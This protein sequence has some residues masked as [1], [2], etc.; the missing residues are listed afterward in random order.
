MTHLANVLLLQNVGLPAILITGV[1]GFLVG[2]LGKFRESR[3]AS[4]KLISL[5]K[6]RTVNK[7][8]ISALNERIEMLEKKNS[9][10]KKDEGGNGEGH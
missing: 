9:G 6:E 2:F 5:R 1:L 8:R 7:Q 10:L 4:R 3:K